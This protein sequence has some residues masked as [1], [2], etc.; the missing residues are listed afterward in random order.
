MQVGVVKPFAIAIIGNA[1]TLF[2]PQTQTFYYAF[3]TRP[4][5]LHVYMYMLVCV[6]ESASV[7]V[8]LLQYKAVL[9]VCVAVL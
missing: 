7:C 4:T 9:S 6:L 3:K 1:I 8:W 5:V 2:A